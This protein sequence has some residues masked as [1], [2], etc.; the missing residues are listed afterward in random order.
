MS[1]GWKWWLTQKRHLEPRQT[2][3]DLAVDV[4]AV[5]PTGDAG[6]ADSIGT[7]QDE[8]FLRF[9]GMFAVAP[10]KRGMPRLHARVSRASEF[11]S[12]VSLGSTELILGGIWNWDGW[13]VDT[14]QR[15]HNWGAWVDVAGTFWDEAGAMPSPYSGAD[16]NQ[17][18]IRFGGS[19]MRLGESCR[20]VH[21]C[22]IRH[23]FTGELQRR[24]DSDGLYSNLSGL[25]SY[26]LTF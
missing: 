18:E 4:S 9:G 5:L 26:G 10:Y 1:I 24:L 3:F 20:S 7:G 19:Y 17:W 22:R 13:R 11:E 23:V 14:G 2:N 25:V 15:Y 6:D 21:R 16:D 8:F 12:D